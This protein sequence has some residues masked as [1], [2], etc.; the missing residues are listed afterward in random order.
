ME[1]FQ[2]SCPIFYSSP[3]FK[4]DQNISNK[5]FTHLILGIKTEGSLVKQ[6]PSLIPWL[7]TELQGECMKTRAQLLNNL[8]IVGL[9][10][11]AKK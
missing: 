2:Q 5:I 10:Q 7:Q 6:I 1:K 8:F 3:L 9:S 11:R 4:M